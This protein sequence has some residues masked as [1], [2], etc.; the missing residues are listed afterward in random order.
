MFLLLALLIVRMALC[1]DVPWW[2]THTLLP[3]KPQS[4]ICVVGCT[5][6]GKTYWTFKFLKSL[7]GMFDKDPPH[8]VI[9]CYG[10][11]QSLFNDME[12]DV[13]NIIMHEGLPT[14]E[15]IDEICANGKHNLIVIDDLIDQMVKSPDM[16]LLLTQ[17]CH[18]KKFSVVYLTQN[19][20]QSGKNAR[21]IALNTWY[22]V[23]FKNLRDA[24]QITHLAKQMYPGQGSILKESYE[25]A[26]K[27]PY[28]YLVID[29]SPQ[30][31][32]K[33]RLR[34]HIFPG[35]DCIVYVPRV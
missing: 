28:G 34:T 27:V 18:H 14:R 29:S 9:Y 26:T 23:L 19:L 30:A 17:G 31:N 1:K 7:K 6:S 15:T 32:I 4:S 5:G 8:T 35:E 21:T 11:W 20:Y 22:L 33:Y 2:N 25:D 16:E 24:S 13:P 12:K 10:V 3:F